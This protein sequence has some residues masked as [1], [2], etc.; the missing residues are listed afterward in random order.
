MTI[1]CGECGHIKSWWDNHD[2]CINSSSS[3]RESTYSTCIT[4]TN[5]IWKFAEKRRI[6]SSRKWV[7]AKKKTKKQ[8]V[9][10]ESSDKHLADGI[11]TPHGPAARGRTHPGGNFKDTCTQGS[12]SLPVTGQ[13]AIHPLNKKTSPTSHGSPVTGQPVTGQPVSSQL[14]TSQS[15]VIWLRK[16]DSRK[17]SIFTG[18][19][20]TGHRSSTYISIISW[21]YS[22]HWPGIHN[23]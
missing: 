3:C 15:L 11:T 6:Y 16:N 8:Q 5:K 13:L 19:R 20:P 7:M 14:I 4:W 21:W 2:K 17:K 22:C 12:T 23:K 1:I 18:Q 9:L 10:S